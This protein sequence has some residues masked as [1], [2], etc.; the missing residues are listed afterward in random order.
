MSKAETIR[1]LLIGELQRIY[2]GR[3]GPTLPDD[4]A[5]RDDLELMLIHA[6][7]DKRTNMLAAWAPWMTAAEAD[8]TLARLPSEAERRRDRRTHT[9]HQCRA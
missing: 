5:G 7:P 8:A 1:R 9:P 3:Y 6:A 4:D 2:R